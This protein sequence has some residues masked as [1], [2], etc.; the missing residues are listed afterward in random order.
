MI[1]PKES[2]LYKYPFLSETLKTIS[3]F[4]IGVLLLMIALTITKYF[5]AYQTIVDRLKT[6]LVAILV[7]IGVV[8][9]A[10]SM[11]RVKTDDDGLLVEFLW[12]WLR[13]KWEDVDGVREIKSYS[14]RFH[15][16]MVESHQL[17]FFH[18]FYGLL[19]NGK[20][21]PCFLVHSTMVNHLELINEIKRCSKKHK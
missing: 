1:A 15:V 7:I 11:P 8:Y 17:T 20:F 5:L 14:G 18:R 16:W 9:Q 6:I 13:I 19:N 3:I 21:K 12:Q 4:T 10:Y 2:K